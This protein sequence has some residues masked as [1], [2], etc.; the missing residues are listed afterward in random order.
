MHEIVFYL[1]LTCTKT[2][3]LSLDLISNQLKMCRLGCGYN[4]IYITI[5]NS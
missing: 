1:R 5:D 3:A 4:N 2:C